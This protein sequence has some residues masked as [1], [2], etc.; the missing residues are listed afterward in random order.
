[1]V[2]FFRF[3]ANSTNTRARSSQKPDPTHTV[4]FYLVFSEIAAREYQLPNR[5]KRDTY[6]TTRFSMR[7]NNNDY[8]T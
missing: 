4:G 3:L 6:S 1:M 8:L 5:E 2:I 7:K